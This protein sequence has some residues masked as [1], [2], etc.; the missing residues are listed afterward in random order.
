[1][2]LLLGRL[3]KGNKIF[4]FQLKLDKRNQTQQENSKFCHKV[5]FGERNHFVFD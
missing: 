3:L 4:P 2:L 5:I 1:M